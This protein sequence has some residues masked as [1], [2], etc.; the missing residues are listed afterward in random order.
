MYFE[1]HEE[2]SIRAGPTVALL[3][4]R[5]GHLIRIGIEL[6]ALFPSEH[7]KALTLGAAD[8]SQAGLAR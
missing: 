4:R 2:D 3:P 1:F 6:N 7:D 5:F 8:Q